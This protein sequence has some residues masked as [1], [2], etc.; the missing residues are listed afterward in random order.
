MNYNYRY[1]KRSGYNDNYRGP[2]PKS[3]GGGLQGFLRNANRLSNQIERQNRA[4]QRELERIQR[5]TERDRI[6][7]EK[8]KLRLM[9]K[10]VIRDVVEKNHDIAQHIENLQNILKHTISVD[11]TISFDSLKVKE[12]YPAFSSP[13]NLLKKKYPPDKSDYSV[14]PLNWFTRFLPGAANRY[15]RKMKE[16]EEKYRQA[17]SQFEK[18]EAEIINELE[19]MKKEYEEKKATFLL[20]AQK[21]NQEVERMRGLYSKGDP[22][23]IIYYNELVLE[24][25]EYPDEFPQEFNTAY[26]P[27]EKALRIEYKLPPLNIIPSLKELKYL[28]KNNELKEI[29]RKD[30]EIISLYKDIVVAIALRSLHEVF[31]ADQSTHVNIIEFEGDSELV[32]K[33]TGRNM[34]VLLSANKEEFQKINLALIDKM[35]CFK[36]L[37]GKLTSM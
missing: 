10:E 21:H 20:E 1:S 18:E 23:A 26:D 16:A 25:S 27:E 30:T 37:G 34:K 33:A 24:R 11:D 22:D 3:R 14:N 5:Q 31:E 29:Q 32:D 4:R 6:K 7:L 9:Q 17:V 13:A 28:I 8:E 19:K 35:T 36:E 15:K 12:E 2:E